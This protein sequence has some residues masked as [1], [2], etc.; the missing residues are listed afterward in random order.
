M[1]EGDEPRNGVGGDIVVKRT[2]LAMVIALGLALAPAMARAAYVEFAGMLGTGFSAP[3]GVSSGHSLSS[4]GLSGYSLD[5]LGL[6]WYSSTSWNS[7]ADPGPANPAGLYMTEYRGD[8]G[9]AIGLPASG[10]NSLP[11]TGVNEL[12][13]Y[14]AL[15]L[16]FNRPVLLSSVTLGNFYNDTNSLSSP[17]EQGWLVLDDS[18][19]TPLNFS[20]PPAQ[21]V[22]GGLSW[23]GDYVVGLPPGTLVSSVRFFAANKLAHQGWSSDYLV[24]G[25]DVSA[26]TPEPGSLLLFGSAAGLLG[27]LRRR[28]A[29]L[30]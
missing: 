26:A 5:F 11:G 3:S 27:W 6:Q 17:V 1:R 19:V 23:T 30:A 29:V 4:Y 28:R 8:Y 25:V 24:R 7:G 13:A 10:H 18:F 2:T 15:S 22:S 16:T 20:A 9:L 21:F 14:E 12:D